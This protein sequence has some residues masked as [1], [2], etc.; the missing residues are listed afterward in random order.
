VENARVMGEY[1]REK[2]EGLGSHRAAGSVSGMGLL[3]A[4]FLKADPKRNLGGFVR[5]YC[6][7]NGMILRNNGDILVMAPALIITREQIDEAISIL[8]AALSAAE[9]ELGV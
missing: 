7:K 1:L 4:L 6:W 3:R 5:E 8:S 9:K 2:L